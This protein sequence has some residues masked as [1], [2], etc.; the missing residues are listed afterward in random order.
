MPDSDSSYEF[1]ENLPREFRTT[2]WSVVLAAGQTGSEA[3]H[4][5]LES[6]CRVY[7]YPLYIHVRRRGHD[8]H[9]AQDLTQEFFARLLDKNGLATVDRTKGKFRTFL[10]V[11]MDNFLTNAWRDAHTQ[12]RGAPLTFISREGQRAD[13]PA[14]QSPAPDLLPEELFTRQ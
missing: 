3:A 7:W 2:H 13:E 1:G 11:S 12:K 10:L 14:L 9:A 6:L 4:T 8:A 5:A